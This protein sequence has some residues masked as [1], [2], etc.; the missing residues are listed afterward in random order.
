MALLTLPS[1]I[2]FYVYSISVIVLTTTFLIL[3]KSGWG[4]IPHFYVKLIEFVQKMVAPVPD[5]DWTD[6]RDKIVEKKYNGMFYSQLETSDICEVP[7]DLT[8]AGLEAIIQDDL[9]GVIDAAPTKRW[10]MQTLPTQFRDQALPWIVYFSG[11]AF[12][13]GVLMPIRVSL[14]SISMIFVSTVAALSFLRPYK[15]KERIYVCVTY[16]RLFS[17]GLGLVARYH[18]PQYKPKSPGIAV[19]NHL[20]AN[21]IQI[22]FA[23][24]GYDDPTGYTVTGQ[25]HPGFIGW[26][27]KAS[28]RISSTLWVERSHKCD[29]QSFQKQVLAAARDDKVDPVLL[30]PEGYCTNNSAVIQFRKAVFE[31]NINIY[32]IAIKQNSVLGDAFWKEDSFIIYLWRLFTSWAIVYNVYYLPPMTK[33]PEESQ[34]QFALRV[35]KTIAQA[36]NIDTVSLDLKLLRKKEERERCKETAQKV[37]ST[38]L[39]LE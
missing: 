23:N 17:S 5:C 21:D 15:L 14:L 33:L 25:K 22:I 3:L 8:M 37:L 39:P 38:F 32:P 1:L 26:I 16:T 19:S 34:E 24:V 6:K 11:L 31:D 28:D 9:T 4:T 7:L 35:Q 18:N 12:R 2:S 29:R 13:I 27:E 36:A 20:T 30:F 10:T